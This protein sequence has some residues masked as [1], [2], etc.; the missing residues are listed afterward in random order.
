MLY[1]FKYYKERKQN[2]QGAG[3]IGNLHIKLGHP[4]AKSSVSEQIGNKTTTQKRAIRNF[5]VSTLAHDGR[6]KKSTP[7]RI[8][9]TNSY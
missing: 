2:V 3:L 8:W 6:K 4:R 9:T 5:H 1:Y 7:L